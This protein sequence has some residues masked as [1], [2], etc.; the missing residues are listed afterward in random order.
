MFLRRRTAV[1]LTV[2]KKALYD[3]DYE[4]EKIPLIQSVILLA[5]W[6]ADCEDR[7]GSW[8]WIGIAIS[9][10]Q[11]IGLHRNPLLGRPGLGRSTPQ[12]LQTPAGPEQSRLWGLIWWASYFRDTWLS[13][14]MGRPTRIDLSDCDTPVPTAE[15]VRSLS[16]GVPHNLASKYLPDDENN[17]LPQMWV[18]LLETTFALGS[19]LNN[20]YRAKQPDRHSLTTIIS[21]DQNR[22]RHC[23]KS[24]PS[25]EA[26]DSPVVLLHLYHLRVYYE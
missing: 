17:A 5:F 11:T 16:A 26:H 6:Y 23:C 19:I 12:R 4:K 20:H 7:D 13:F 25:E 21:E 22:L 3:A 9:L 2:P 14:G 18:S 24:F 8:H 10:C 1:S 15:D